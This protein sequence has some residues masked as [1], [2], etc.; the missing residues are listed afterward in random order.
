MENSLVSKEKN[1]V[2]YIDQNLDLI[3]NQNK[4][5]ADDLRNF[6]IQCKRTGLDPITRQIYAI[7]NNGKLAIMAS[8]DGLRLIADRSGAYEGQTAPQWCD[9]LGLWMDVWLNKSK[10]P[11]ACK[12]GVHKKNFKEP[13]IAIAIFDEYAGR[14]Q[15]DDKYGKHKKGD[16]TYMWAKMPALMIAKVAESLALRKA[17]PN[18]MSGIYSENEM[19]QANLEPVKD[20]SIVD[21]EKL[22][23]ATK[24]PV[25]SLE[26]IG[27]APP[28]K[29]IAD[30]V[31]DVAAKVLLDNVDFKSYVINFG[32]KMAGKKLGDFPVED[33]IG[34]MS[35]LDDQVKKDNKPLSARAKEYYDIANVYVD[36]LVGEKPPKIDEEEVIPF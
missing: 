19:D 34:M 11:S 18:E 2:A 32:K 24:N 14:H 25:I 29:H 15:Y 27:A 20:V 13:L 3:A 5:N 17:F 9:E 8:I 33:H 4:L 6:A 21:K 12:V 36:S 28:K 22:A 30:K 31:A 35:W 16:L 23:H 7:P 10:M 1:H 26:E